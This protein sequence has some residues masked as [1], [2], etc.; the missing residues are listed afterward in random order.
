MSN[1]TQASEAVDTETLP[2]F[3]P[4][5]TL[6]NVIAI[7][8]EPVSWVD[9][10]DYSTPHLKTLFEAKTGNKI[11]SNPKREDFQQR[12]WQMYGG[13]V[14][15]VAK[16]PENNKKVK[17]TTMTKD[18][19]PA[20]APKE[21]KAPKAAKP[22][23][24]PKPAKE[25]KAPKAPK[26]KI[27]RQA[28]SLTIAA[29]GNAM[30]IREGSYKD[31]LIKM[32][33]RANGVSEK[34]FLDKTECPSTFRSVILGAAAHHGASFTEIAPGRVTVKLDKRPEKPVVEKPAKA[35]KAKAEKE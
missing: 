10:Q 16:A 31:T 25:A 24:A 27:G 32:A 5:V 9:F 6:E 12:V 28:L 22:V 13:S 11:V 26:E 18:A 21:T 15:T 29:T 17:D 20:K 30:D 14:I 23:K 4:P 2:L 8:G 34:E 19:K 1:E 7:N 3:P 33:G 35:T